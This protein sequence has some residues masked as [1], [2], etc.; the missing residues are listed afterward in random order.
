MIEE[1]RKTCCCNEVISTA[2]SA[3]HNG[4]VGIEGQAHGTSNSITSNSFHTKLF[5]GQFVLGLGLRA[6]Y[7]VVVFSSLSTLPRTNHH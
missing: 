7:R 5:I 3:L 1:K 4:T 2:V 6:L